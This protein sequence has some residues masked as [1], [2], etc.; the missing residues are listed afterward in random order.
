MRKRGVFSKNAS[1]SLNGNTGLQSTVVELNSQ[2]LQSDSDG[3]IPTLQGIESSDG[4]EI[5]LDG[6]TIGFYQFPAMH[7]GGGV[8]VDDDGDDDDGN[9]KKIVK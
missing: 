1:L 4:F 9:F 7:C 2:A 3:T 5:H 6:N 8:V